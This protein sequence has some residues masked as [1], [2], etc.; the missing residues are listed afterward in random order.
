LHKYICYAKFVRTLA[1]KN[2]E[3]GNG[4]VEG[5]KLSRSLYENVSI[6][7]NVQLYTHLN[8]VNI[9][10]L[11]SEKSNKDMVVSRTFKPFLDSATNPVA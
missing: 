1:N 11:Q 7:V 8:N 4:P 3:N 6:T 10:F 5:M 2:G 9:F